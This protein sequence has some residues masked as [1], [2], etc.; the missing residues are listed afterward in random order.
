MRALE[1]ADVRE[2]DKVCV[3][4]SGGE[5]EGLLLPRAELG[6]ENCL[7]LKLD[8]GYNVG[9]EFSA[10]SEVEL[11]ERGKPLVFQ[12]SDFNV[13]V[14][15]G[16]PRVSILGCGG[17][18]AS[19]IEYKTGAVFPAFSPGDLL[20][21]APEL[22]DIASIDCRKLFSLL[23][24]DMTPKHWQVIARE[25]AVEVKKGV[26]GIV[27]MHG[28]D[29]MSYTSAALS[30]MLQNL[31]VPVV[32]V[33]SQRSSDRGSSDNA[34]NLV[35]AVLA[36]QSNFAGVGVCM[37]VNMNDDYCFLHEGTRVRKLHTSRRDAFKSVNVSPLAKIDYSGR[38]VEFLRDAVKRDERRRVEVD[39]K[40]NENVFLLYTYPGVKPE[41]VEKLDC[42]DGV[43][44]AGT[45]LGHVPTNPFDDE[46]A[47]SI[48]PSLKGL[49]EK[50]IPVV[51][52]PQTIYGRIDLNVYTAGRMLK[53]IGVIGDGCDW[54]PETALVK[55][56]WALGHV[57][58]VE[59]V[60]E[61]MVKNVAGEVSERSPVIEEERGE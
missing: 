38:K 28:T 19:R 3:R 43:V 57:K 59:K 50:G 58:K 2:G 24:E 18:I 31:P 16:K 25:V 14:V 4:A 53:E 22:K 40:M 49:V 46:F 20:S 6:G 48:V 26:E 10:G 8:S 1:N 13:S 36:A 41:F 17:T 56:M 51:I 52:A 11:V 7:V 47:Q 15:G 29:T 34:V 30:F 42:F 61:L 33:G 45:G 12:S 32:L 37:H 21:F 5:Y 9:V 27:L 23:S 55:L 60:R 39:D 44:V 35:C 54:L